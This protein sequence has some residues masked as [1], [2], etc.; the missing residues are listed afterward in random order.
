MLALPESR[1]D[2]SLRRAAGALDPVDRH[3]DDGAGVGDE[4]HLVALA[5]DART[6]EAPFARDE[7]RRLHAHRATALDRIL[8]D[9]GALA[10][11]VLGHDE[12]VGVVCRDVDLDDLVVGPQAHARHA[13]R[14][15]AHRPNVLLV[16]AHGLAEPRHHQDVVG[17]V[18]QSHADQLVALAHLQGDDPVGLQRRV[19]LEELRLLDHALAGREE[20]VLR[21]AVVAGRDHGADRLLLPERQQ[22]DD[23]AAL[24]LARA[25]RQLVDLQPVDLADVRE[26]QDEV[27][28]RGHEQVLDV[29]LVLHL[30][31][32][33]ADAAA[34]LLAVRGDGQALDVARACDRDDHVLLGDHVL[35]LERVLAHHDL[36]APVVG[37]CVHLLD[38]EQLLANE[39]V[40]AGR[41]AQDRAQ[42][43]DPFLEVGVLGLDLLAREAGQSREAKVE[44]RLRLDLG[45]A[46][47]AHQ[48]AARRLRVV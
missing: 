10:P 47:L 40:D 30:H 48:P 33:H 7:L 18:R 12:Q 45:E 44:D 15:P 8:R 34:A 46:E 35:Q 22:V 5:H 23:R 28:R 1:H 31:P 21:L 41:V 6:G 25:Q 29:V 9:A 3:A 14:V 36:G 17:A 24:R 13:R 42:L 38:L 19:V 27:V 37:A 4:H 20:Q 26:E 39:R 16:E 32:H 43:G 2:Y 11:A